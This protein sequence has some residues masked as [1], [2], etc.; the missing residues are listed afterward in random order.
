MSFAQY[1]AVISLTVSPGAN[2]WG[3]ANA[4]ENNSETVIRI[5]ILRLIDLISLLAK[6]P[7]IRHFKYLAW[8]IWDVASG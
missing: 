1:S 4:V 6:I 2:A 5:E 3:Y 7:R 8:N